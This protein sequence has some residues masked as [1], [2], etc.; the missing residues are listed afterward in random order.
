MNQPAHPT[1]ASPMIDGGAQVGPTGANVTNSVPLGPAYRS[2]A[3]NQARLTSSDS[4]V[5]LYTRTYVVIC[6]ASRVSE[7]RASTA[8]TCRPRLTT[9]PVVSARSA[10]TLNPPGP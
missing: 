6:L 8:T 4:D 9:S 3:S 2:S 5:V 10:S 7:S 1:A